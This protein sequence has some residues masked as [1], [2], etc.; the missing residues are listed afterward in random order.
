[1]AELVG[2]VGAIL[3]MHHVYPTQ[4]TAHQVLIGHA[5]DALVGRACVNEFG[6]AQVGETDGLAAGVGDLTQPNFL[7]AQRA[8]G[9]DPVADILCGAHEAAL[10]SA[11]H[12]RRVLGAKIPLCAITRAG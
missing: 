4:A 11:V 2:D 7:R 10:N 6:A 12:E 1:M 8:I 5:K 3:G 9:F